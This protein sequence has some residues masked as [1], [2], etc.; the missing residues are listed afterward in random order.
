[1]G[2]TDAGWNHKLRVLC[3]HIKE[4]GGTI[5]ERLKLTRYRRK[6]TVKE[7]AE[8]SGISRRTIQ[9]WEESGADAA[10]VFLIGCLAQY[11]GVSLEWLVFGKE[12]E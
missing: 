5:S 9:Y 1:M 12:N 4:T 11:Y 10:G 8:A 7:V 6:Q 3:A 2:I